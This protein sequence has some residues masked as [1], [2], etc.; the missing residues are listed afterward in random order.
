[1]CTSLLNRSWHDIDNN[2]T[3]FDIDIQR[4]DQVHRNYRITINGVTYYLLI[5]QRSVLGPSR[6]VK[7][8]LCNYVN[9]RVKDYINAQSPVIVVLRKD[10]YPAVRSENHNNVEILNVQD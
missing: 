7:K 8:Y 5:A 10:F 2:L 9:T 3:Y 6:E 4:N 1:M